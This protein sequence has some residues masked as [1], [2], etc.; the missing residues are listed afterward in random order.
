MKERKME[1]KYYPNLAKP[2]T[3]NG[4]TF[5]NRIFG[6][7][8]SNPEM[9]IN[10]CMRKEDIAFHEYRVSGGLASV[11]IGLGVVE[12]NGRT[13]TKEVVLYDAMSLPSLKE[14]SKA[15]HRKNAKAVMEL[16]HG[17]KYANARG[18]ANA[19]SGSM[20]PNDEVNS[21]GVQIRQMTDADIERTAEAFADAALL[22]QK[23]DIDMILIHAGHGWL[24][25]QFISSDMNRRT[26]KWGG[27]LENRMR[28]T[29]L[30]LQKIREKVG[31]K[32]PIEFRMSGA[33]YSETG[34]GIEEGIEIAKM[35]DEY[36]DIIH[37]SA[38]VHENPDVFV[39]THPSMFVKEG[40]NTHLAIEVKKHVKS[41][42]ATLGGLTDID[43]MEELVASGKVDIVEIARQSICDPAL[44]EKAFTGRK[45]DIIRCCRC[46][47]CFANYLENRTYSCAFNPVVGN[48]FE[49]KFARP[50]TTP[51]KVVVIGGGPGGMQAAL[52]AKERG[53][54]V[55]IYEKASHLGGQLLSEQHIPFKH[56]MYNY[57]KV[58][59]SRI[60]KAGIEVHLNKALTGEQTSKLNADVIITAVGASQFVPP[61]KGIDNKKVVTL[62]ALHQTPPMVGENVVIIGG[63]LVGAECGIYLDGLGKKVTIVEMNE[64]FAQ[65]SYWMHK[66]AMDI[67]I[68]NSSMSIKTST[69][70]IE[71]TDVGLV[72]SSKDG[73]FTIPADTILLAA[74]MKSNPTEEFVGAAPLVYNIGDSIKPGRVSDATSDAFYK[75]L[76][77]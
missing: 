47:T 68:R 49:N 14:Y 24:I 22:C 77:I 67:Y 65:D 28:F 69:K 57:V 40:C 63:G 5:K 37:V 72:C 32:Y 23:A 41:P 18:H 35:V 20:G 48:E 11:C 56:N 59:S 53:H 2:I 43:M 12:A 74:G 70:A 25:H 4:V 71:V 75:A 34:Y 73:E 6:A 9:D 54:S 36:V 17:G 62:D 46:F 66:G 64:T 26:D 21:Q 7:P 50:A 13:H 60:E 39:L 44:P 27:S 30:I 51:K 45:D 58:M 8:M 15:I 1:N 33:E 3:I 19:E 42:V 29:I 16:T 10:A 61:I 31:P 38:G 76:D 55:S 52:T